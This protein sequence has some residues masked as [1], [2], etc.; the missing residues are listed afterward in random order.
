VTDLGTEFGVEVDQ[1]GGTISHVFRGSVRV[2]RFS[3]AGTP[4]DAGRI[5]H[6]N[7]LARVERSGDPSGGGR[8]VVAGACGETARFIRELPG[9]TIKILDLVDVVAGG[10]GFSGRRNRGIDPTTGR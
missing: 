8:I 7:E 9:R 3:D 5:L 4:Q 2:Q 1:Q 10:D 6:Q